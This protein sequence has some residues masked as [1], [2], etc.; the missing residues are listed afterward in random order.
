FFTST[1]G[2]GVAALLMTSPAAGRS[3]GLHAFA[4]AGQDPVRFPAFVV[5]HLRDELFAAP[6]VHGIAGLREQREPREG[7]RPAL[8]HAVAGEVHAAQ[9]ALGD[10]VALQGGTAVPLRR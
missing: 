7:M 2:A 4:E 10:G 6:G 8:L 5:R 9:V 3:P 1:T